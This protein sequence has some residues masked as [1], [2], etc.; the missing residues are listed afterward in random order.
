MKMRA[1]LIVSA[2]ALALCLPLAALAQSALPVNDALLAR[3]VEWRRDI[4]QHPELSNREFRTSAKVAEHLRALGLT[5]KT[6]IAHTG[7]T[8][9]LKGGKPGPRMAI[10]ADMDALPVTE[11]VDLPFASKATDTYRGETVGVMHAC[12]HDAHTAIL[13]GVAEALVGVKAQLA[14]E[15]MFLFQPAEEGPPEG[16]DGGA[17]MMLAEGVFDEFK[18]DAIFALHVAANLP[19]GMIAVRQGPVAA[20]SDSFT[21]KVTGRQTHGSMPWG[22]IDPIVASAELI[23]SA[24]AIISRRTDISKLPAVVTFGAIRGGVR[25]NIIPDDVELIGTIRTFDEGMREAIMADLRNVAEHVAA[26]H[27]AH[28]DT[29]LVPHPGGNPVM[30]NDPALTARMRPSLEKAIGAENVIEVP[31]GMGSEDHAYFAK[32]IPSMYFAV[33]ATPHDQVGKAAVN[34]SPE[35]YLD[36]GS[37]EVGLR[38][39]LQVT[40][41]YLGGGQ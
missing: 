35:F 34:H 36:E 30:V 23:T 39:M 13:M 12:G 7:V 31:P 25:Y 10:R 6:G 9:V 38:A 4:H 8:A 16:E 20:A 11:R 28:A 37:L 5:P 26:A 40:M 18:P 27:G 2:C 21:I 15:V 32:V 41:D 1:T 33:G 14:G 17:P 3:V 22:G 19:V 24:Q 29:H